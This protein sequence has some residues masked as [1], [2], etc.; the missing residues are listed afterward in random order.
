M[1]IGQSSP[2]ASP[3]SYS[4]PMTST[5]TTAS[6]L[7]SMPSYSQGIQALAAQP[8]AQTSLTFSDVMGGMGSFAA[9]LGS[10]MGQGQQQEQPLQM[11]QPM[12]FQS[13]PQMNLLSMLGMDN[14]NAAMQPQQQAQM[15]LLDYVRLLGGQ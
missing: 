8:N 3:L 10:M 9:G 4:S 2:Y 15:T 13:A 12:Q 14:V 6:I 7:G 1:A 11:L 5:P